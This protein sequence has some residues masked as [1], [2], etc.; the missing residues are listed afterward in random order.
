MA[1]PARTRGRSIGPRRRARLE[2]HDDGLLPYVLS[3]LC[4]EA[5]QRGDHVAARRYFTDALGIARRNG[6]QS[7]VAA[8]LAGLATCA[9]ASGET[10]TDVQLHGAATAYWNR[11][12]ERATAEEP[13]LKSDRQRLR[14]VLGEKNFEI[15]YEAGQSLPVRDIIALAL[16]EFGAD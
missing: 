14:E 1:G 10:T 3:N 5:R 11:L 7:L 4:E 15:V 9:T 12:S 6:D 16:G 8:T 2:L 13:H